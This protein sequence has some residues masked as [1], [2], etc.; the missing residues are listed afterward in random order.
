MKR[1]Q[2]G[3]K[4]ENLQLKLSA[5]IATLSLNHHQHGR[6]AYQTISCAIHVTVNAAKPARAASDVR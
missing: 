2:I 4:E 6:Q 3:I 1:E 5:T